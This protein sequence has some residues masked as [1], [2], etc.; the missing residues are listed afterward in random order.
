MKTIYIDSDFMCHL[1][2]DGTMIEIQTDVFDSIVNDA[3][4]YYR[5][6]PQGYKWTDPQGRVLN[7]IFIQATNSIKIEHIIQQ[8]YI[9]DMQNALEIL[10]V[11]P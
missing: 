8:A 6:I 9:M 2:D 11:N 7:G 10:G 1:E 3:I 4:P 5:Y